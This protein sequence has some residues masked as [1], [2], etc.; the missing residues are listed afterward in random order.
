MS[1]RLDENQDKHEER[2]FK[3]ES[4][5]Y[6]V[7]HFTCF[8]SILRILVHFVFLLFD[9]LGPIQTSYFS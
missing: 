8:F 5:K 7:G 3:W 9:G 1:I 2:E 4:H 6:A